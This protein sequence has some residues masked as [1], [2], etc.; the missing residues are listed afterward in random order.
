MS[1]VLVARADGTP[2]PIEKASQFLKHLARID[3]SRV[4]ARSEIRDEVAA[5]LK[6]RA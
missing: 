2:E 4:Y 3:R 6:R 1:R 5:A